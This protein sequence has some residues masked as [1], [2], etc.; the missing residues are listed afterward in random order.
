MIIN[1]KQHAI[2][3]L[4]VTQSCLAANSNL[5]YFFYVLRW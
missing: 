3:P 1:E 2:D 5:S 4:N